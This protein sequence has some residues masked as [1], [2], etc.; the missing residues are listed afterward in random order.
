MPPTTI[1]AL[2]RSPTFRT[3]FNQLGL[4][5]DFVS[6]AATSGTHCLTTEAHANRAFL[7]TTNVITFT[8]EDMEVQHPDHSKPLYIASQ[9]NDVHIRRALVD[10]GASLN[11]IPANTLKAAGIPLNRIAG[12]PIEVFGFAGIH[13][14][15]IGSIQLALKVG[16]IVALTRFH[17]ID[18]LETKT[19]VVE[20]NLLSS[21]AELFEEPQRDDPNVQRPTSVNA[22]LPPLEKA[23][24]ISLLK[25][26][27][28]VFAWEYHEMPGLDPN[29]V[30][31]ALNVEPGAKPMVQPMWTFH[32]NVEAQIIQ[33]IQ[34]LLTVVFIKPIMH[35]KWLSNIVL[36]K[37]KNGQIR[38]CVDFRNLNKACPKDEFPL[39]NMDMLIDLAAGHA[40]F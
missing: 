20:E 1:S 15:T 27:I 29:L 39:P 19:L 11:L 13:E 16:P 8:D 26:Y 4:N 17:V 22:A 10:T 40:M 31:H 32:P 7:E 9:V 37:K 36:V 30:S 23:Q 3:L 38:C 18:S 35:P 25:E 14:C 12:A 6:I 2:Q 5:E 21:L 24:L 34:K 33:E 28:D